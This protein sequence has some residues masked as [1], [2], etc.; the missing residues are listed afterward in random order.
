MRR[1]ICFLWLFSITLTMIAQEYPKVILPGDYPDPTIVRDGEDYYMTH[2]PFYYAPG[3]L[4]W[5]SCNLMDWE[6]ITRVVPE[7][8][9][10]AMASGLIKHN[11]RF[12][13]YYPAAGTNW[14]VWAD[15]IRGPWSKP[16]DLKI[17]GIDIGHIVGENGKRYLFVSDGNRSMPMVQ[18]SDEGLSV[19]GQKKPVYAG[20]EFP[21]DW[22]TEGLWLESPKLIKR[23]DYFYLT[24][25]EGG[26]AG[27]ATS[28]MVVSARSKSVAGSWEKWIT[29]A[30]N[31]D[32]SQMHHNNYGGFY[33]LSIG[34]LS[35]G[36]GKAG[37]RHFRYSG[38]APQVKGIE[39]N[40]FTLTL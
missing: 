38:M 27:P 26:T 23:G 20:W 6:P 16:V 29:I 32:V 19:V 24:T 37:F 13:L 39:A 10:S 25:A 7:Y 5:H 15:D 1:I 30:E 33:A 8:S 35:A 3:F 11:R 9:G 21:K 12:Y 28:H 17:N 34:L 40:S 14:V 22:K 18:L 4:I 31:I 36:K 2:S